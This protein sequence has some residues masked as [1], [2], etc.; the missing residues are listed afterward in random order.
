MHPHFQCEIILSQSNSSKI[1]MTL[2][3]A[4]GLGSFDLLFN[5]SVPHIVENIFS[6]LHY[7]SFIACHSVCKVWSHLL[8][9]EPYH[10]ISQELLKEKKE[11]KQK[12]LGAS[13]TGNLDEIKYLLSKRVDI[14]CAEDFGSQWASLHYAALKCQKEVVQLLINEGADPDITDIWGNSPL[15]YAAHYGFINVAKVLIEGGSDPS[16]ASKCRA[17]PLHYAV[18]FKDE[19]NDMTELLLNAGSDPNITDKFGQIPLHHAA[20]IGCKRAVQLLLEKGSDPNRLDTCGNT[21]L[22]YA[23]M[24][25]CE[26]IVQLLQDAGAKQK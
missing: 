4:M 21:P 8:S 24:T 16:K 2:E 6:L 25:G 9:V 7:D 12:L 13:S 3:K 19:G 20:T 17:T 11:N 23:A 18:D 22:T 5:K 26:D 15:H 14:N 10:Q 1:A